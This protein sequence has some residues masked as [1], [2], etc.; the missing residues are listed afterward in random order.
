LRLHNNQLTGEI[1]EEICN[2]GDT[3]PE[4]ENNNLCPP[5]PDCISYQEIV[6]QNSSECEYVCEV[7]VEIDLWGVCINIEETTEL[8]FWNNGLT[9][10]IPPEIGNLTNLQVLRL[11]D[12]QLIGEIPPEVCDL[13]ESNSLNID[14]I[15]D[16]NN[17]INTCE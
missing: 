4:L 9:G 5:Y 6:P 14:W 3:S 13:I 7:G 8:N 10:E 1:P 15:L 12:N 16:G 11:R 2:Q 17:L